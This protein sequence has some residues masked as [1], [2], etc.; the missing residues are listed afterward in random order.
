MAVIVKYNKK[1][2]FKVSGLLTGTEASISYNGNNY[3]GVITNGG[4]AW[5]S[6]APV[7]KDTN[8][9]L[10]YLANALETKTKTYAIQVKRYTL[11]VSA[12]DTSVIVGQNYT[13]TCTGGES[14]ADCTWSFDG[15]IKPTGSNV[16]KFNSA[17]NTSITV[18]GVNG[19]TT[20]FTA[21]GCNA[22]ASMSLPVKTIVTVIQEKRTF[23]RINAEWSGYYHYSNGGNVTGYNIY[24][25]PAGCSGSVSISNGTIRQTHSR[26]IF[27]WAGDISVTIRKGNTVVYNVTK[28]FDVE[29]ATEWWW[30]A[31]DGD[32]GWFAG[33][34]DFYLP[35]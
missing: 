5:Y 3:K 21:S 16:T 10:T 1:F 12:S 32:A 20:I 22:S 26:H 33:Y 7:V 11:S 29:G 34:R 25:L 19:G 35:F 28:Y 18:T 27:S 30:R 8:I 24:N 23:V 14:G 6:I 15:K 17:G 31:R 13:L 2:D 9:V 4:Y